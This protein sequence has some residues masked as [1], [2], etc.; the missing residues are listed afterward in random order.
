MFS[1]KKPDSQLQREFCRALSLLE[2]SNT[3]SEFYAST[4]DQVVKLHK[5][6]E[7]ESS[8]RV[9]PDTLALIVANLFGIVLILKHERA[10]IITSKAMSLLLRPRT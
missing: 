5:M 4:V 9:K 1:R 2:E 3:D 8:Y 10:D 7:E 6:K